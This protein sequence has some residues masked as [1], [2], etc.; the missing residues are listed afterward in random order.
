MKT[1]IASP[2]SA[3][4]GVVL[5]VALIL[6]VAITILAVAGV[7][8]ATLD[9]RMASNGQR[10]E[11]AFQVAETGIENSIQVARAGSLGTSDP[12][13][14]TKRF[15]YR[16]ADCGLANANDANAPTP[17]IS[18]GL[19][20]DKYCYRIRYVGDAAQTAPPVEGYSLGTQVRPYHYETLSAGASEDGRSEHA[21]GF[22]II[23]PA[24]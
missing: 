13:D 21:Q 22:Y 24:N 16:P 4:Q 12:S 1:P 23:G 7:W 17:A 5:V 11:R 10:Q 18:G 3:Q 9:L 14:A 15:E 2:A 20:D 19:G 6:L 8:S